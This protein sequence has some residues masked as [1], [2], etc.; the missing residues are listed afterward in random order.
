[1][2]LVDTSVWIRFFANRAP[3]AEHLDK[4]LE[5]NEV[6]GHPFVFGELLIG[7]R[8]GLAR[9]LGDYAKM[10]QIGVVPHSDVVSFV[11]ARRLFGRGVGWIDAHLLA[12]ATLGQLRLWSAD[13][14][15]A[16]MAEELGLGHRLAS[17]E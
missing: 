8:G 16:A 9:F 11:Q 13:S 2:V 7:D 4:L 5:K 14:K 15:L 1:M 17:Q 6:V 10:N 3:Y 12:S